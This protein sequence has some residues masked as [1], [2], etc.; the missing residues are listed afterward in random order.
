M[1][2]LVTIGNLV[3]QGDRPNS[4]GFNIEEFDGWND[5]VDSRRN[6]AA[7]QQAHGDFD[8][9]AFLAGRTVRMAGHAIARN[10]GELGLQ[11]GIVTGLLADGGSSPVRA[12]EFGRPQWAN[13]RRGE[14]A[15]LFVPDGG[16]P[17]ADF[18]IDLWCADP[19]K[20][21]DDE[22]TTSGAEYVSFS[23]YQMGNFPATPVYTVEGSMASGYQITGPDSKVFRV[24]RPLVS[25]APHEIDMATGL[26][27]IGGAVIVGG[28]EF[29]DTWTV[30]PGVRATSRLAPIG[31]VGSGLLTAT[32]RDTFV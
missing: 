6:S 19:R 27:S 32:V 3:A 16:Q 31:G 2:L 10:L 22:R 26:L 7:R 21:G 11:Q 29:G 20:F 30:L 5:G 13:A 4:L 14:S 17:W 15:P 24:T 23:P 1:S 28:V 18:E 9:P 12:V 8:V 25:G